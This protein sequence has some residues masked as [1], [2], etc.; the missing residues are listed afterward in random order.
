MESINL[1]YDKIKSKY[2]VKKTFVK[3]RNGL[4]KTEVEPNVFNLYKTF[5]VAYLQKSIVQV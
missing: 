4:L 1:V 5:D 3:K 2:I